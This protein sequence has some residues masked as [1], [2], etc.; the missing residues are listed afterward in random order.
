[1]SYTIDEGNLER[2]QLLAEVLNPLTLPILELIPKIPGGRCLD[3]GCGQGHTTRFL[4]DV[5]QPAECIGLEYDPS[6]VEYAQS[7]PGNSSGVRFQQGEAS[8]LDFADASFDVAFTRY[9]LV[10]LP[11]PVAVI[12]E[13]LRVVRPGGYVVAYEPDCQAFDI[14]YPP[15]TAPAFIHRLFTGM[16]AEPQMGRKLVDSFRAAGASIAH[17]GAVLKMEYNAS[18]LKRTYRL[19]AEAMQDAAMAKGLFTAE[20]YSAG[21]AEWKRLEND[22]QAVYVKFPDMWVIATT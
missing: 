2:Q 18:L 12:R 14:G 20:E 9:L 6:L 8:K 15:S 22:P 19:S 11:D 5:L 17:A 7:H 10:H 21:I 4:K 3:L 13:M 1:M 16:F